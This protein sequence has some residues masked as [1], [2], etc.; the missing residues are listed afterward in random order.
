MVID[1][2]D[3]DLRGRFRRDFTTEPIRSGQPPRETPSQITEV[4]PPTPAAPVPIQTSPPSPN[5]PQ[6]SLEPTPPIPQIKLEPTDSYT[7]PIKPVAKKSRKKLTAAL[8]I[9]ALGAAAAGGLAYYQ[10]NKPQPL[11]P[12]AIESKTSIPIL[13]PDKLPPGFAVARSSFNITSGNVVA[14]YAEDSAGHRLNFTVQPRPTN[15]DFEKFYSQIISNST[16]FNTSLG[17]AA[18]GKANGHLLGSLA[19]TQSWVLVTGNS[20]KVSADQIQ[21]AL[22]SLKVTK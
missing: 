14:Y 18:I 11:V 15:F 22:N 9:I 7:R 12:L 17:E 19:T 2:K 20:D 16:R 13:Y 1:M 21:T 6:P 8:L 10:V 5:Q 3:E 4:Q